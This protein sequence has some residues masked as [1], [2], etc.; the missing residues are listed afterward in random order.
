M[1]IF[2]FLHRFWSY[3]FTCSPTRFGTPPGEVSLYPSRRL[4]NMLCRP[5]WKWNSFIIMSGYKEWRIMVGSGRLH[6]RGTLLNDD[7][8]D[9][10]DDEDDDTDEYG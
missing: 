8:D 1:H 4:L 5:S 2:Y 3:V 6:R 7:D 9:D 10:D